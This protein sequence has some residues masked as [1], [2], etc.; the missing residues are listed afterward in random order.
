M[1]N[2]EA[3][4]SAAKELI[5]YVSGNSASMFSGFD[6][7]DVQYQLDQLAKDRNAK[8]L[9]K[10]RE[11]EDVANF[12]LSSRKL[13]KPPI[14][15]QV[16]HKEKRKGNEMSINVTRIVPQK[17]RRNERAASRVIELPAQPDSAS[18]LPESAGIYEIDPVKGLSQLP[19]DSPKAAH[20]ILDLVNYSSDSDV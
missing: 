12:L 10:K 14:T 2:V 11:E 1:T 16:A 3:K 15:V 17:R 18:E 8:E 6:R 5:D 7:S 19:V 4:D 13:E 20:L 9:Q